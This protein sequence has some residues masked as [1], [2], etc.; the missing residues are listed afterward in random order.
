MLF[1]RCLSTDCYSA[2]FD[3]GCTGSQSK[4]GPPPAAAT[5]HTAATT[6]RCT[7]HT[8]LHTT[9]PPLHA[10]TRCNS[11]RRAA[12][13]RIKTRQCDSQQH[14]ALKQDSAT[15][16]LHSNYTQNCTQCC[17][18]CC[19]HV[20]AQ[21]TA[22]MLKCV[23]T[24]SATILCAIAFHIRSYVICIILFYCKFVQKVISLAKKRH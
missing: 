17:T 21:K 16:Q 4:Q 18:Q 20:A 12:T 13:R 5:A 14:G 10:A 7:V 3:G 8:K 23:F 24:C 2:H 15:L 22:Q 6:A 19:T 9:T 11:L 1:C